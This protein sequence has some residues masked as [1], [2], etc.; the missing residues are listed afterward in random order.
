MIHFGDMM[1][2]CIE[3]TNMMGRGVAKVED[4]VVFCENAVEGDAV[5]AFINEV[6]KNYAK[7]TAL[8]VVSPSPYRISNCCSHYKECGGCSFGHVT[9]EHETDVKKKGISAA[10]RRCGGIKKEADGI[11]T[12]KADGYRNKAVFHFDSEKNCCF[13]K[14]GTRE[15]LKIDSC[16]ICHPEINE[17]KSFA[18]KL[19]KEN[20]SI[21]CDELTYLY[22]RYMEDTDEA[23]VVLGYKGDSSLSEFAEKLIE[24]FSSIKCIMR[25]TKETPEAKDEKLQLI[26]GENKIRDVFCGMKIGVSPRSFYQVNHENAEKMCALA[27]ELAELKEGEV[28]LDLYCGT[29]TIGLTVAKLSPKAK[30]YGVEINSDAVANAKENAVLNGISNIEFFCGDSKDFA[31]KTKLSKVDC[32]IV[33]PPRAGL[34]K[35]AVSEILR[36]AP[37]KIIYISCCP[38]TL[39][40]DLKILTEKYEISKAEGIDLFPKTAHVESEILLTRKK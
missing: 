21:I 24:A 15:L 5:I 2:L 6:K 37:E 8:K 7:A 4:M 17:I 34:S 27:A 32:I 26:W 28:C 36:F 14:E 38:D 33:D 20:E 1:L 35:K 12:G 16:G 11:I 30:I 19:L 29:G 23:S 22:I 25:G 31:E 18:E 13:Y 3:E 10:F 39:A 40:R 9:Y